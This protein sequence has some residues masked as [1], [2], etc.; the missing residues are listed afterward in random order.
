[1]DQLGLAQ[2]MLEAG[3][4][5][6]EPGT[7]AGRVVAMATV[8]DNASA[9]FSVLTGRPV[10]GLAAAGGVSQ[11]I[12]SIVH[13]SGVNAL[14]TTELSITNGTQDPAPLALSYTYSGTDESGTPVAGTVPR[15][16]TLAPRSSLPIESG[17]DAVVNLF[18]RPASS[19]TSGGLRVEGAAVGQ[20]V[21]RA[22]ISTPVDLS[23]KTRGTMSSEFASDL[24]V[25]LRVVGQG[26][27][28]TAVCAGIRK[29]AGERVNLILTEMTGQAARVR[30][31]AGTTGGGT[32]AAK[33]YLL[34][35][36]QK[37]Q[38]NDIFGGD[39]GLG[40]G[41]A[42]LEGI[43][44]TLEATGTESGRAFGAL[45]VIDNETSSS[46]ILFFGPPGPPPRS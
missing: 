23:D 41:E 46:R 7:G 3:S 14:F 8:V 43:L 20:V 27:A 34:S 24:S 10:P 40:L 2:R 1:M 33:E 19:N 36:N 32:L 31:R 45:T 22:T 29:W 44:F 5:L 25:S 15:F 16:L 12:P 26:A 9:S 30:L 37:L 42:P 13:A 6:V 11:A 18:R 39:G 21:A 35:A 4:L 28:S 38:V 17:R